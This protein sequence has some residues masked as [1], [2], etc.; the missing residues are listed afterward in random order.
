[1]ANALSAPAAGGRRAGRR[2][3]AG[4]AR[5]DRPAAGRAPVTVHCAL[6]PTYAD[7]ADW[8]AD[9][10]LAAWRGAAPDCPAR[11]PSTSRS[12]APDHRRAG[13]GCAAR[14][15]PSRRRCGPAACRSRWSAWAAC[16]TP[17]RSATWSARCGCWPTRPTAAALLRLLT[18][19]RWRIGPRDLVALH[20]RARRSRPRPTPAA[21]G[22]SGRTGDL[23]DRLDEATLV[24]A[25]ADLGAGAG[26]L[27]RG[28]RAAARVRG[29]AGAAAVPAGPA[30]CP[31]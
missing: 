22:E 2:A 24:E 17:P 18:G 1:M 26:V 16:W 9:S 21:A 19:A 31:T 30:A 12:T 20:R 5:D 25:L 8:I 7:E 11:C 3:G 15:R 13:P 27:G 23:T 29:G 28:L 14:S 4:A 6:L 10:V